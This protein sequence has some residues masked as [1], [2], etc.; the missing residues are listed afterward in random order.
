[1]WSPPAVEL[2]PDEAGAAAIS[3]AIRREPSARTGEFVSCGALERTLTHRVLELRVFMAPLFSRPAAAHGWKLAGPDEL[4]T[5]AIPEAMRLALRQGGVADLGREP[6]KK[7]RVGGVGTRT[8][9][10]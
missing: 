5:L 1:M 2:R 7:N 4:R 9:K 8:E 3:T 10:G 6:G